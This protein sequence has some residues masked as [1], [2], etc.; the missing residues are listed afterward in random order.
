[1]DAARYFQQHPDLAAMHIAAFFFAIGV[2]VGWLM[3]SA[4]RRQI[5]K[6]VQENDELTRQLED[7]CSM[8]VRLERKASLVG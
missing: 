2:I 1:M 7:A 4:H 3:W 5:K 6:M 8:Q